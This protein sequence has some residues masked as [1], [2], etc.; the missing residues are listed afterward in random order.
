MAP[1]VLDLQ[2]YVDYWNFTARWRDAVGNDQVCWKHMLPTVSAEVQRVL[3]QKQ[4]G[5]QDIEFKAAARLYTSAF[6]PSDVAMHR[7]AGDTGVPVERL[8][9]LRDDDA[10]HRNWATGDSLAGLPGWLPSRVEP[11]RVSDHPVTCLRCGTRAVE[12]ASCAAT[13]TEAAAKSMVVRREKGVDMR[14]GTELVAYA[15]EHSKATMTALKLSWLP[16]V[17]VIASND[18]DYIPAVQMARTNNAIVVSAAWRSARGPLPDECTAV[19]WLDD[20][21][22]GL[23]LGVG[24]T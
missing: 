13:E 23:T 6:N 3:R 14:L 4:P 17:A 10:K 16:A 18:G 7:I 9:K 11:L 5:F 2:L 1:W 19:A 21:R 24:C 15:I 22:A 20:M 12:C 8:S